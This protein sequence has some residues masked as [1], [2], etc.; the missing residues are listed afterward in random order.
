MMFKKA[1]ILFLSLCIFLS[2][3][4]SVFAGFCGPL[5]PCGLGQEVSD[6][7]PCHFFAGFSNLINFIVLCLT[8]PI[9]AL[10]FLVGGVML[11]TSG[12]NETRREQGKKF[13]TNTVIALVIIYTSWLLLNTLITTIAAQTQGGEYDASRWWQAQCK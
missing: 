7:T 10:M 3:P 4:A 8:P 11:L 12:G 2:I 6:C 1:I 9:A 13:F 5:V